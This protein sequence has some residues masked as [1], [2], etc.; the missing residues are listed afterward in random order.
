MKLFAHQE[1]ALLLTKDKTHVAIPGYEG[2]YEIDRQGNVYSIVSTSSR[3]KGIIKQQDNGTGYKRVN[4]FDKNGKTKK[5]YIHRLVAEAFIPNPDNLPEV[6]HID[7]NKNNNSV[8]NLEWCNRKDN[9][10]HSYE[11]G[12]K[13]TCE[14]HGC[15]K[16][17]WDNVHDIRE[18]K[19]SQKEYAKK[20][21]VSQSTISAIQSNKL[22]KEGDAKCHV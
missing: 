3:R 7:C 1:R 5:H 11:N 21:K 10:N 13:R 22:W 19:L 2:L 20:Y 16:L 4:L 14:N 12:L 18:K 6:N 17:T 9:L 8:D 15:H